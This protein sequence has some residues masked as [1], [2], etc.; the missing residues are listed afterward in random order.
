M[1]K[2]YTTILYWVRS[3]KNKERV[4]IYICKILPYITAI[5]YVGLI[6]YVLAFNRDLVFYII[7]IPIT[8]FLVVTILRKIWNR[9]RPYEIFNIQPLFQNK[10]GE[11]AP[12]RHTASAFA[13][14]LVGLLVNPYVGVILCFVASMIAISR[15]IAGVHFISDIL[16]AI[17]LAILI[18]LAFILI[19]PI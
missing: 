4:I 2:I 10:I 5:S 15:F 9:S 18:Y 13:I 8:I 6:I 7:S 16:I 19:F 1:E 3:N 12:S 11:S 14:A 17:I